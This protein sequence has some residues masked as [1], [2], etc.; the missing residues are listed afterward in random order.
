MMISETGLLATIGLNHS[1][2]RTSLVVAK[3]VF[4]N[5]KSEK[6]AM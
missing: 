3:S 6:N 1:H 5:D 2:L 4:H